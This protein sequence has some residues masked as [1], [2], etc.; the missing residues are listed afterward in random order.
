MV[1]YLCDTL[2]NFVFKMTGPNCCTGPRTLLS[3]LYISVHEDFSKCSSKQYAPCMR[4]QCH[5]R[6]DYRVKNCFVMNC[7]E[8]AVPGFLWLRLLFQ[9]LMLVQKISNNLVNMS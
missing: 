7:S 8:L 5:G 4:L 1:V 6:V 2:S 9:L 3:A